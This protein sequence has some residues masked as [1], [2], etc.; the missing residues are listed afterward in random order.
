M[1]LC[2]G[3]KQEGNMDDKLPYVIVRGF[4]TVSIQEQVNTY[5]RAGYVPSGSMVIGPETTST[6]MYYYQPMILKEK[7][8]G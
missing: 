7:A 6:S 1:E 2:I 5:M 3:R 4:D 8:N